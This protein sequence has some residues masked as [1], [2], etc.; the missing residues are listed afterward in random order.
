[1]PANRRA[2]AREEEDMAQYERRM[3]RARRVLV[4]GS[5]SLIIL[6]A[7]V[8]ASHAVM[9]D[10]TECLVSFAGVPAGDENGGTITCTDCDPSCD[11]D[12]ANNGSCTFKLS[13]CANEAGGTCTATALQPIKVKGKCGA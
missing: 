6:L 5:V 7:G 13:V 12:G 3:P 10:T 2:L 4:I 1:M 9:N 11:T 8:P